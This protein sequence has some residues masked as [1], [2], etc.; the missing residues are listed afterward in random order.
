MNE[1]ETKAGQAVAACVCDPYTEAFCGML[2]LMVEKG[3]GVWQGGNEL[4][5]IMHELNPD[6]GRKFA[7]WVRNCCYTEADMKR[8]KPL[9]SKVLQ[10]YAGKG[11]A[12]PDVLAFCA[13]FEAVPPEGSC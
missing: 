10:A 13:S 1:N 6:S 11:A 4:L 5:S 2:A 7:T 3:T 12:T 9:C 8:W